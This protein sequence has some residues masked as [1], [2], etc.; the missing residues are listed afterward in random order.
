MNKFEIR[1]LSSDKTMDDYD[2]F[3]DGKVFSQIL[4]EQ[5]KVSLPENNLETFDD[6]CFAW[7]KGLDFWGDVR[8]VWNLIN[9]KKA[10]VPILMCPDDLDFSC[11]VLVVEVEKTENTI[12]WKRAGSK[13]LMH[14]TPRQA[15]WTADILKARSFRPSPLI[16]LTITICLA[17]A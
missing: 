12:I 11:V 10:I 6:L 4:N 7:S 8:F 1:K 2:V 9:R 13:A 17:A 3:I 16:I 15:I 5:K 14:T